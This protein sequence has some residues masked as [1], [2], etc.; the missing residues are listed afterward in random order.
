MR[1]HADHPHHPRSRA[2]YRRLQERRMP[3]AAAGRAGPTD[4]RE[5]LP[6]DAEPAAAAADRVGAAAAATAEEHRGR[7]RSGPDCLTVFRRQRDRS[8]KLAAR[9]FVPRLLRHEWAI[10]LP[11]ELGAARIAAMQ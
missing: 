1:E 5:P 3:T 7:R 4:R 9:A 8:G 11:P 2:R 6:P 10:V